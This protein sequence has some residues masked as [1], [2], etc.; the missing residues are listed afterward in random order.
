MVDAPKDIEALI[1]ITGDIFGRV[2]ETTGE[3]LVD[4]IL[5]RAGQKGTGRWT[6]EIALE[7]GVAGAVSI[8]E[9]VSRSTLAALHHQ[10]DVA[11][12]TVVGQSYQTAGKIGQFKFRGRRIDF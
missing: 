1:E 3:P 9:P 8:L 4:R 12:V 6:S 5:D 7:L 11:L 2:D 10:H